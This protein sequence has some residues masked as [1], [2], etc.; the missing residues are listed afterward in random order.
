MKGGWILFT[1]MK[2]RW[3]VLIPHWQAF[4][5]NVV[6]SLLS[7]E[8][9]E[10]EYIKYMSW[11]GVICFTCLKGGG[12]NVSH[13]WSGIVFLFKSLT[14]FSRSPTSMKW[15]LPY[16]CDEHVCGAFNI[17]LN[18]FLIK[19]AV[20]KRVTLNWVMRKIYASSSPLCI[21]N[22]IVTHFYK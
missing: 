3:F 1:P 6:K 18:S 5:I 12:G 10:F 22:V 15:F 2:W 7:W 13:T 11:R 14:K 20:R 21:V 8:T 19:W 4:L 17:H 16:K 9:I